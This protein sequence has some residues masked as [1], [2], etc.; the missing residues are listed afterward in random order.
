[1]LQ[2]PRLTSLPSVN[3]EAYQQ[4]AGTQW[5]CPQPRQASRKHTAA[6]SF[7]LFL[8]CTFQLKEVTVGTPN[9]V[10]CSS[11]VKHKSAIVS[12]LLN[13]TL[14]SLQ[15]FCLLAAY[16]CTIHRSVIQNCFAIEDYGHFPQAFSMSTNLLTA[17]FVCSSCLSGL[18]SL[19]KSRNNGTITWSS[20]FAWSRKKRLS[21]E[22][23]W[24]TARRKTLEEIKDIK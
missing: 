19:R 14:Q 10:F 18:G 22:V 2:S 4:R 20:K 16:C 13:L 24:F 6:S 1:M 15:Q 7:S 12:T 17:G 5:A 8:A 23:N 3:E 11:L 9:T 21:T